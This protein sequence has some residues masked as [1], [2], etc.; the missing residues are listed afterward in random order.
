MLFRVIDIVSIRTSDM[1]VI[2]VLPFPKTFPCLRAEVLLVSVNVLGMTK[3][4]ICMDWCLV[5][6]QINP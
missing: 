6:S 2:A 3:A 5:S 4:L 1:L